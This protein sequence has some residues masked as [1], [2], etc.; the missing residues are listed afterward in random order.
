[1]LD[2]DEVDDVVVGISLDVF[3]DEIDELALLVDEM[4]LLVEADDEVDDI[5]VIV[6]LELDEI[7]L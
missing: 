1:M 3:D 7:E 2:D 4:R 5:E 6:C